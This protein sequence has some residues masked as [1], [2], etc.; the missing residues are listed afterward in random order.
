MLWGARLS[1]FLL[2]HTIKTGKDDRFDNK[3]D[4]FFKFLAS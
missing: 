1:G 4:D 2:F 3:R